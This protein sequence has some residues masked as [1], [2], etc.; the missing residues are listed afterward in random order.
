[1]QYSNL[2]VAQYYRCTAHE[3]RARH[4]S[5]PLKT[6]LEKNHDSSNRETLAEPLVYMLLGVVQA[7]TQTGARGIAARVAIFSLFNAYL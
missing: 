6:K 4:G 3:C 7:A 2:Q 5:W 1:M